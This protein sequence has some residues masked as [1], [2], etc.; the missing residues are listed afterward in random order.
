MKFM[1]D[2][3]ETVFAIKFNQ[4]EFQIAYDLLQHLQFADHQSFAIGLRTCERLL[5]GVAKLEKPK[6]KLR[7]VPKED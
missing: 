1:F 7:L 3:R 2:E 5:D 4:D 6:P